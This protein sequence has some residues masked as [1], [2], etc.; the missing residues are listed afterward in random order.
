MGVLIHMVQQVQEQTALH[1]T[2]GG[3][4]QRQ[5]ALLQQWTQVGGRARLPVLLLLL[6]SALASA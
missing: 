2:V 1:A 6:L 3:D 5:L 4:Q